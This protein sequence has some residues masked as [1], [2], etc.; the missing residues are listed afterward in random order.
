MRATGLGPT[1]PATNMPVCLITVLLRSSSYSSD[2][3]VDVC[4]F[5][6]R[7]QGLSSRGDIRLNGS[8]LGERTQWPKLQLS[9]LG[10]QGD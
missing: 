5:I 4:G 8:A 3:F 7:G 1:S 6:T 10:Q 9:P 2:F